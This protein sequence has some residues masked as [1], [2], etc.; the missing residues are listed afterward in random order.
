V[1]YSEQLVDCESLVILAFLEGKYY[2]EIC[3]YMLCVADA[4]KALTYLKNS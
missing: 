1:G 2:F 3:Q 4:V